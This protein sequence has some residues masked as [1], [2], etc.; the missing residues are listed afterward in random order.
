L[1]IVAAAVV[2]AVLGAA[3][4][5]FGGDD[6]DE[7]VAAG[8]GDPSADEDGRPSAIDADPDEVDELADATTT[9]P[10]TTGPSTTAEWPDFAPA[11]DASGDQVDPAVPP[12]VTPDPGGPTPPGPT[13]PP[14][15]ANR[16]QTFSLSPP[17]RSAFYANDPAAPMLSWAL[18]P[19]YTATVTGDH[20]SSDAT[21][22][23]VAVCPH[24]S[25]VPSWTFC[26]AP[27]GQ[28]VYTLTVRLAGQ[29]V[30]ERTIVLTL[31]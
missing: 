13:P 20:F 29:V 6:G 16:I 31:I 2:V 9:A 22:G 11:P 12:I 7:T 21:S 10:P 4:L 5:V 15:P 18:E 25:S 17:S 3:L 1:A 26:P 27:A 19:G 30:E 23:S 8:A 24:A 28:Y 14:P